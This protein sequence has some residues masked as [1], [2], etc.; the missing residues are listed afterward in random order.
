[1]NMQAMRR[2]AVC[3]VNGA[4]CLAAAL[5]F[6][7]PPHKSG[8]AQAATLNG[9]AA[10]QQ[11]KTEGAYDSLAAA[12]AAA[13]Q[14]NAVSAEQANA[15]TSN[16]LLAQQA[17]LVANDGAASDQFGSA[18]AIS[19]DTA[20]VG[21][22]SD[23]VTFVDQGSAYVFV[24]S[25]TSWSLQQK[26][27]ILGGFAND[28]LGSSVAISGDT[29]VVGIPNRESRGNKSQGIA[30]VFVRS[31]AAWSFQAEL[32]PNDGAANDGFG[33]AVAISGD[34]VT[35]GAPNHRVGTKANQG[36]A[37]VFTR[38]GNQWAQQQMLF[39]ND[40][41][42]DDRFGYAVSLSG[43][44]L[45]VGAPF[46]ST[47][48]NENQGSAYIFT[49]SGTVWTQRQ[50]LLAD[51]GAIFDRFGATLAL[52]GETLVVGAPN[53]A[54]DAR[55]ANTGQGAAY[56]F[57]HA[58]N[59][60]TQQQKLVASDGA[61]FD[62]F[63]TSVA[64]SG[65]VIAIG[66]PFDDFG[67]SINQGTVYV[68]ARNGST[69]TQQRLLTGEDSAPNDSFGAAVALSGATLLTGA[70]VS[71]IGTQANQGAAY[72]FAINATPYAQQTPFT[73]DANTA[74]N[75]F[76]TAIAV[77][78]DTVAVGAPR[79][80]VGTNA[81]QGAVYMFVRNGASWRLQN[82]LRDI[83]KQPGEHFGAALALSGDTVVIGAPGWRNSQTNLTTGGVFIYF[84]LNGEWRNPNFLTPNDGR[85]GDGFGTA[86]DFSGN[87]LV[88]GAPFQDIGKNE[89]QGAAY[90]FV[91][92]GENLWAHQ[93]KFSAPDGAAGDFFGV[94]V[95]FNAETLAVGSPLWKGEQGAI[96]FYTR[97][98]A[99]W[100]A[101][102]KIT[103]SDEFHFGESLALDGDTLLAGVSRNQGTAYVF[104]RGGT[105]PNT[106]WTQQQKL[107]INE[108]NPLEH[109]GSSVALNRDRAIIGTSPTI[110]DIQPH[111]AAYLFLRSG[112][113]WSQQQKFVT[114][115]SASNNQ[116]VSAVA[117]SGNL[118]ALGIYS[119]S[120]NQ[121]VAYAF[122]SPACPALSFNPANL[123]D[124][125]A[126]ASY[127]QTLTVSGGTGTY[128]F[129]LSDGA[130]PPGLALTQS[131]VLTGKPTTAGTYRF[132]ITATTLESL[133][134]GS[135]AYTLT[136]NAA[137]VS[138]VSA[139]SFLAGAAPESIVAAFG[140]QM[141]AQ[142]Q[143]A[144]SV[145]LPTTLAGVSVR[146]RDSA[147][148][149]RL[150]PLFFVSPQQINFQVPTGT[151]NGAATLTVSTGATG[152]LNITRS[153][154]GLFT[155]NAN[156]QGVPAAVVLRVR[157]NGAQSFEPLAR[158]ENNHFV[159]APIDLG[160]AGEQVF[161]VLFGTG[162]RFQQTITASVG[163]TSAAVLFTGAVTGLAG[164]DQ[165]NLALPR[166]LIGRGEVD[167]T[168]RVDGVNANAV[169]V[170]VR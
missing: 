158:L 19:G 170:S 43:E 17:K 159:P 39:A 103:V 6:Q 106:N 60:W 51:D 168:L 161:L 32:I 124:A 99:D 56:V 68:F 64:V 163:G 118:V 116:F 111:G 78:G 72:V 164:L 150:A 96:Y 133:C 41:E 139:A 31:N 25:G 1:M 9:A 70:V 3:A 84:R 8:A 100:S 34:T 2:A 137:T 36:T 152:T 26:L 105:P 50:K 121:G 58:N 16:P 112:T 144:T 141:A 66:A 33:T 48:K 131:G 120:L 18:L 102:P 114:P 5:W 169:R 135:R 37:Y 14:Q 115:D 88:A 35:V 22:P 154:P 151:A 165:V 117:L 63:G 10:I 109:F 42:A 45:A 4:V 136:V 80:T 47:G 55:F 148:V 57:I 128:Q 134:P 155:A 85:A 77:S 29:V 40:G 23:D 76:G 145:P 127:S 7:T 140:L 129:S 27:T 166:T 122:A 125:V 157:A 91:R 108:T 153:A 13:R 110:S 130:L 67:A 146:V 92:T 123:P 44:T 54:S 167:V 119:I 69:W 52:G 71:D 49:R 73:P 93:A 59:Q 79:E 107:T 21:V 46:D 126:G 24:R 81:G 82:K 86:V 15:V 95:A 53:N 28:H 61:A 138:C 162:L 83:F 156:G 104:V 20:V 65:D 98:N 30:V 113:V 101:Q 160:A 12:F 11:L 90:V 87:T 149:E 143:A 89:D 62:A 147:G 75:W 142:T 97:G 74:G 38:A 132:T 94:A